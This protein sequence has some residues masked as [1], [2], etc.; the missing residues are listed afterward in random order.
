LERACGVVQTQICDVVVN[1]YFI[2]T[3]LKPQLPKTGCEFCY[4][5]GCSIDGL[6]CGMQAAFTESQPPNCNVRHPVPVGGQQP[7]LELQLTIINETP[8]VHLNT[9]IE[10]ISASL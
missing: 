4:R 3:A 1:Y 7:E 8:I 9:V 10:F 5:Q 6:F 2:E